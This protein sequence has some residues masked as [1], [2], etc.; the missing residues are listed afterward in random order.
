MKNIKATYLTLYFFLYDR[1]RYGLIKAILR[2]WLFM[3]SFIRYD[4]NSVLML[5]YELSALEGVFRAG[6][7]HD[8]YA[9]KTDLIRWLTSNELGKWSDLACQYTAIVEGRQIPLVGSDENLIEVS[10]M[11]SDFK[12]KNTEAII[13]GPLY[14]YSDMDFNTCRDVVYIKPACNKVVRGYYSYYYINS[15]DSMRKIGDINEMLSDYSIQ[16]VITTNAALADRGSFN[17]IR[18][19]DKSPFFRPLAIVNILWTLKSLGYKKVILK[20][21]TFYVGDKVYN[22]S[23]FSSI[24]NINGRPNTDRLLSSLQVHDVLLNFL[25]LKR[26]LSD[27]DG[28]ETDAALGKVI[29]FDAEE[30]LGEFIRCNLH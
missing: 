29:N 20:G 28:F 3:L 26:A 15:E 11:S 21:F 19:I 7:V 6:K 18:L 14:V 13:C 27:F 10:E 25:L 22:E 24:G 9:R 8:F 30:F 1:N 4:R 12:S 23:Y 2:F 16:A 17:V 5:P